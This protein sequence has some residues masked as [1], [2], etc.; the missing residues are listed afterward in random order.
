M[1]EEDFRKET[2]LGEVV[3][4]ERKVKDR[5]RITLRGI[6]RIRLMFV[7]I[8]PYVEITNSLE[9]QIRRH[10]SVRHIEA[11]S[12]PSKKLKESGGKGSVALGV[13]TFGL[14]TRVQSR[15]SP[16]RFYGLQQNL[17]DQIA[18]SASLK[19]RYTPLK[20]GKERVHRQEFF[21]SVSLEN[22][23]FKLQNLRVECRKKPCNEN[24]AP[25][26][27]H[28]IWRKVFFSSMKRTRPRSSH[29]PEV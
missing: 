20:I 16:S 25:A 6:V 15:R 13:E 28:G 22:A 7:C 9:V 21:K 26:E 11:D 17:E 4:P 10:M 19:A 23:V 29:L 5:A 14:R 8:L 2:P 1:T 27:K 12:Q 18:P 3:H 24:D